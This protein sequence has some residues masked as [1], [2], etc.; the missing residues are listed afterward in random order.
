MD[1]N[2]TTDLDKIRN[3][4]AFTWGMITKIY[5]VGEYTIAAYAEWKRENSMIRVGVPSDEI[6]Y[7]VWVN[8]KNTSQSCGS[9]DQALACAIAYKHEGVNHNADRY[10][11][12]M[13]GEIPFDN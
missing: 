8:G 9:L 7:H 4:A 2:R 5:E 13:I 12:V 10:F 6:A 11:M 1:D 3:G